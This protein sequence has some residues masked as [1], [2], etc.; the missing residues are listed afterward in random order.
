MTFQKSQSDYDATF[1]H[2]SRFCDPSTFQT[3]QVQSIVANCLP[4]CNCSHL[5]GD[6][7]LC[8][9]VNPAF[10]GRSRLHMTAKSLALCTR[11]A[12][13]PRFVDH[14]SSFRNLRLIGPCYSCCSGL[15]FGA[16]SDSFEKRIAGI[17]RCH[18]SAHCHCCKLDLEEFGRSVYCSCYRCEELVSDSQSILL[19]DQT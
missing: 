11:E 6:L 13:R 4:P 1:C 15:S 19:I 14:L 8:L 7:F 10:R 12:C 3:D 16:G 17:S 2:A 5:G 18:E 9:V